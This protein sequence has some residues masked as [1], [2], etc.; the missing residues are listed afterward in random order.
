MIDLHLPIDLISNFFKNKEDVKDF[1]QIL[2]EIDPEQKVDIY[3][4]RGD[5]FRSIMY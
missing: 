4:G 1:K 2:K 5:N 3:Y